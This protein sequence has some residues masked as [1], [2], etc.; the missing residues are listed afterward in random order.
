MAV[1]HLR[2]IAS[3]QIG[4]ILA[5]K[6]AESRSSYIYKQLT[7]RSLESDGINTEAITSFCSTEPLQK[8][9]ISKAGTIVM[10]LS[11]PFNPIVITKKTEGYLIPS[12]MVIIELKK[13]ILAEYLRLYLSQDFVAECLLANYFWIAQKAITVDSLSNLEVKVPSL[14]NQQAICDCYQN[15]HHLCQL[16]KKLDKEEQAMMKYIFSVLSKDKEYNND[17]QKRH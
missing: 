8:E 2:D 11:A 16:R 12:Q 9:Y 6:K 1:F 13:S 7:L 17:Y 14:K 3:I 15:Y 4:L 5:R 10:K